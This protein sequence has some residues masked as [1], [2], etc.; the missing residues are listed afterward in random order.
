MN[1]RKN[2][3]TKPTRSDSGWT[4][5]H[6]RNF[7]SKASLFDLKRQELQY[8]MLAD[9]LKASFEFLSWVTKISRDE[10]AKQYRSGGLKRIE[11]LIRTFEE[12]PD[13][14]LTFVA[15]PQQAKQRRA[16]M[17]AILDS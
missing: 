11:D 2:L 5:T 14:G 10:F 8:E 9:V 17:L 6:T 16:D 4:A 1:L 3:D 13:S 12:N 15:D 7:V